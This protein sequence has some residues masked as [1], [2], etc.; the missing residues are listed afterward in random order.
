MQISVKLT[1]LEKVK[2]Q[3]AALSGSQLREAQAKA[4]ND[5]AFQV[6]RAMQDEMKRVFDR[7]TPYIMKSIWIKP[8][9]PDKPTATIEA[10]D[11]G[12]GID[13]QKIL[14]AQVEGGSR[15]D[16]RSE[17]ALRR[18]GY[19]PSG[20]MTAIPKDPFPGSVDAFGNIK[21]SFMVHLLS[22]L[23][24]FGEVGYRANMSKKKQAKLKGRGSMDG[25]NTIWGTAYFVSRGRR[26]GG[27]RSSP[28]A[29]GIWA[30]TGVNG[31]DVKPVLMFVK[32]P[33]Y[34]MRFTMSNVAK[35]ADVDNYFAK[36]MRF[37]IRQSFEQAGGM[38]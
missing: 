23:Q 29:E 37:R 33:N 17:S 15:R 22:Y 12:T 14:R 4:I 30:K 25:K 35:A 6:K 19:L 24:A 3:L 32:A 11:R 20:Y 38:A 21:G 13:P 16:K 8:A 1:G 27:R 10:V 36:R 5:T 18:I 7:P 31:R 2:K 34:S 28:L 26:A 9:T